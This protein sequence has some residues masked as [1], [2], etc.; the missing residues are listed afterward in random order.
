MCLSSTYQETE[1]DNRWSF[2]SRPAY[3]RVAERDNNAHNHTIR[4]SR[5]SNL[6]CPLWQA[7]PAIPRHNEGNVLVI[8]A[9]KECVDTHTILSWGES[10]G[11]KWHAVWFFPTVLGEAWNNGSDEGQLQLFKQDTHWRLH[12]CKLSDTPQW[13]RDKGE[14]SENS[15]AERIQT[16]KKKWVSLLSIKL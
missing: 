2:T 16:T 11:I 6:L 3:V 14:N 7:L 5:R 15:W 9:S 10:L 4:S 1:D 8:C 12:W 13:E